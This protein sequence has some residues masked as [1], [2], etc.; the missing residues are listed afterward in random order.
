MN[1]LFTFGCSYTEDYNDRYENYK[2]YK[3]FEFM[4]NNNEAPF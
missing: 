1:T 2:L 4:K 3:E